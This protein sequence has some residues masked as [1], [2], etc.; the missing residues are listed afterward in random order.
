M[1]TEVV[2]SGFTGRTAATGEAGFD[3]DGVA[4]FYGGDEGADGGDCAGCFVA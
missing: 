1:R 2:C 4:W 3:G